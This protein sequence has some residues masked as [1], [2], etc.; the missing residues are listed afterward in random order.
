MGERIGKNVAG[1]PRSAG[2][3][4]GGSALDLIVNDFETLN[5]QF[6]I[7]QSHSLAPHMAPYVLHLIAAPQDLFSGHHP[8]DEADTLEL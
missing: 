1:A 8:N 7:E 3:M 4:I 2:I 5:Q 6:A